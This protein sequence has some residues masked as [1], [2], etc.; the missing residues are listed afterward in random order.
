MIFP[1]IL[2]ARVLSGEKTVHR[3]LAIDD[4]DSPWWSERCFYRPR[5]RYSI[6]AGRAKPVLGLV[7]VTALPRLER[8]GDITADE[9]RREG[10]N[11]VEAFA[12]AWHG[13][14]PDERVWRVEFEVV[15]RGEGTQR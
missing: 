4:Q 1:E 14:W 7:R 15:R 2:V 9:A 12:N 13:H 8:L 5:G 10:Y 6:K 11:S 3:G